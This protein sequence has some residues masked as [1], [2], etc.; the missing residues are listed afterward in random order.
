MN[1][2]LFFVIYS[3]SSACSTRG[4]VPRV[5][6]TTRGKIVDAAWA[7]ADRVG[8]SLG[9]S[10]DLLSLSCE[11]LGDDGRLFL[12]FSEGEVEAFLEDAERFGVLE[13]ARETAREVLGQGFEF[14]TVEG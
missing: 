2:D 6:T 7:E 11:K 13:D 14:E 10:D 12:I 8:E 5:A 4:L 3:D 1:S 9:S